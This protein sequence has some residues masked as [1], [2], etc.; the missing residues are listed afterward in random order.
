MTRLLVFRV[1]PHISKLA[2]LYWR[3]LKEIF[4]V[5]QLNRCKKLETTFTIL[6][7]HG[8][9][10]FLTFFPC[11]PHSFS[12][13]SS[14]SAIRSSS[15]VSSIRKY[16]GMPEETYQQLPVARNVSCTDPWTGPC[17]PK[18]QVNLS[19]F[20][21]RVVATTSPQSIFS[22][23]WAC[24]IRRCRPRSWDMMLRCSFAGL[25]ASGP[26]ACDA[27]LSSLE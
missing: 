16:V 11:Q 21:G 12:K 17:S 9:G 10:H 13:M 8:F 4:V 3:E 2:N 27:L 14:N 23:V 6:L 7:S 25:H 22:W 1:L 15:V 18:F 26:T 19:Q 24:W 5:I 20:W